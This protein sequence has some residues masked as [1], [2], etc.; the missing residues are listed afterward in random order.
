MN[1]RHGR[2]VILTAL[3]LEY[4]AVRAWLSDS[5]STRTAQGLAMSSAESKLPA[6][7]R[8]VVAEISEDSTRRRADPAGD[9]DLQL[10]R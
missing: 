4:G 3:G 8:R 5:S 10:D 9:R 1:E 6:R 7:P 2:A